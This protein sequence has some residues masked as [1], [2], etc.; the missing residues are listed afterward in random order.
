MAAFLSMRASIYAI[1]APNDKC[2]DVR[3]ERRYVICRLSTTSSSS[4]RAMRS[5]RLLVSWDMA[6]K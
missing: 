1:W 5:R 6:I 3:L 4:R 2:S